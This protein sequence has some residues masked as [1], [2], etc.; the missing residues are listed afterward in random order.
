MRPKFLYSGG[1]TWQLVGPA[2]HIQDVPWRDI[3][4]HGEQ[5]SSKGSVE[6]LELP[7]LLS[8]LLLEPNGSY[9]QCVDMVNILVV[10]RRLS[11][12]HDDSAV[13]E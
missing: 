5:M 13:S 10:S 11:L 2:R 9:V 4:F 12:Y 6:R 1:I 7:V 8:C 3:R